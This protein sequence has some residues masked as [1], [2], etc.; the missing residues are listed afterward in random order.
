MDG[1]VRKGPGRGLGLDGVGFILRKGDFTV[2]LRWKLPISLTQLQ[3]NSCFFGVIL[4]LSVLYVQ[5]DFLCVGM[6]DIS[7]RCHILIK[8]NRIN[9]VIPTRKRNLNYAAL[10]AIA[11]DSYV[12]CLWRRSLNI[13]PCE[14]ISLKSKCAC[15]RR[16]TKF[17][18]ASMR[19]S[20]VMLLSDYAR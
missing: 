1:A 12:P 7:L 16:Q 8:L 14:V 17:S 20:F 4:H 3:L 6:T 19:A 18:R 13:Q 10:T 2:L 15:S 11:A 9:N 5:T